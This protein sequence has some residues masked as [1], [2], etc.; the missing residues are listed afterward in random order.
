MGLDVYL[1]KTT[2]NLK[3]VEK[4]K[5]KYEARDIWGEKEKEFKKEYKDFTDK[6]KQVVYTEEEKYA[7]SLGLNSDGEDKNEK[8]IEIKSKKHPKNYF[9]IGYFRSSYN[10]SGI[11]YILNDITG[12]DLYDIFQPNDEY[13]VIPN[14]KE[15]KKRAENILK[16]LKT[17]IK[18]YGAVSVDKVMSYSLSPTAPKNEGEAMNIYKAQADNHNKKG[19]FYS[20]SCREGSF[21]LKTPL[22][23]KGIMFGT[24]DVFNKSSIVYLITESSLE[25][26]VEA[27]EIVIETIDYVLKQQSKKNNKD[28]YYLHWSG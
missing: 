1:Y 22:K 11:N 28:L 6:E 5:E 27:L 2:S 17:F 9:K 8:Q 21:Y 13:L 14:W 7:L 20:Y 12:K 24:S 4:L 16:E 23:V 25:D 18:N 3:E 15:A 10:S 26:Y 19:G